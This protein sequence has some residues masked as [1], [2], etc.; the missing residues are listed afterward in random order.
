VAVALGQQDDVAVALAEEGA[1]RVAT[2]DE[3]AAALMLGYA[4]AEDDGVPVA[5]EHD[6][7]DD[8]AV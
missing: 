6:V 5:L 2:E 1:V 7:L 8:A 3:L 4:E